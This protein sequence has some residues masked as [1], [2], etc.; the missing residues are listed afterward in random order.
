[1]KKISIFLCA[2][3]M[4][5]C[6]VS[7]SDFFDQESEYLIYTDDHKIDNATDSAYYVLGILNKLQRIADRTVLL[8]ELRGDLVN[9]TNN[10]SNDLREIAQFNVSDD[11]VYN[12]PRDYYA[13][14]NNCNY[15][16]AKADTTMKDNRNNYIFMKEYAAVKSIRAWTYLQLAINYG[17]VALFTEPILTKEASEANYPVYA[18]DGICEFFIKDLLPLSE[19]YGRE[20]PGYGTIRGNDSRFIFFPINIVLGDFYLWHASATGNVESYKNAALRYYKFISE[21]NGDNST[22]ATGFDCCYWEVGS[23]AWNRPEGRWVRSIVSENYMSEPRNSSELITMIPCDSIPAEGN[24]SQLTSLFNSHEDN[25]YKVSITPSLRIEEISSAQDYCNLSNNANTVFYA[26]KNL[27]NHRSGD[28]RLSET[29]E[30]YYSTN[31]FTRER[32]EMQQI[33]KY[34]GTSSGYLRNVHIYRRQMVY[35]RMAEALNMAGYPRMAFQVLSRGLTNNV[36]QEE[37]YPY[38][39][40]SDS[41]WISQF[42]FPSTRYIEMGPEEWAGMSITGMGVNNYNTMGMHS[43]GCGYTPMNEYYKLPIDTLHPEAE[44]TPAL[45]AYVNNLILTEGAL[46]FAFEGVR[47]YDLLRFGLRSG[48]PAAFIA[49]FVSKRNGEQKPDGS[50]NIN[51]SNIYLRWNGLIGIDIA[52]K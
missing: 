25:D 17:K 19:R 48:S 29:W 37:V 7:C 12:T 34:L 28:L 10:A 33:N 4:A 51:N 9:V 46:E 42:D 38:Y 8:G 45:Q 2:I 1:M 5:S 30:N 3:C 16:L 27:I 52:G 36:I 49:E 11:N 44:Q 23:T 31:P 32:S 15:F 35:L 21:R 22:Y 13:I 18:I 26:P 41:I 24:Y 43:R 20:Y 6:M 47:Y 14:I 40:E 39:S 50:L